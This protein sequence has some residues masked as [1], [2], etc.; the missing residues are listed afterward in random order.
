MNFSASALQT[1][2]DWKKEIGVPLRDAL[3]VSMNIMGR[4]GEEACRHSMIL[5]AQSARAA[6][7]QSKVKRPVLKE[8]DQGLGEYVETYNQGNGTPS[9]VFKFRFSPTIAAEDRLPGT[10]QQAKRIANR[11]MAKRAWMWGLNKIGASNTG[12]PYPGTSR[13]Y[14]ILGEKV[15]GYIKENRLSYIAH[16]NAMDAGWEA[17]VERTAGNKI[18]AQAR[19]K[20]EGQWRS[21]MRRK[22]KAQVRAV[23]SFFR[24]IT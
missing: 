20:I 4:T 15:C 7:K 21:A 12:K 8:T 17:A 22:D 6:T 10:W 23:Q 19:A 5:M 11:G 14:S 1:V 18:M 3:A 2:G 13:F 9:R 24:A 16:R